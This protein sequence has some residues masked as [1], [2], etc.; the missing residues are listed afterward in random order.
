MCDVIRF[1]YN[2]E[3]RFVY[4]YITLPTEVGTHELEWR[5]PGTLVYFSLRALS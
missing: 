1:D 2:T 3:G 4:K 5:G